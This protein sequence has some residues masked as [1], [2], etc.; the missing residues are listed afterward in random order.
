MQRYE[1]Y[2]KWENLCE[3]GPSGV[4]AFRCGGF[5]IRHNLL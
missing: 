3:V 5:E 1:K 4:M 2:L